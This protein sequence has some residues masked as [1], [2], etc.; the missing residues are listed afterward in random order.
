MANCAVALGMNVIGYDPFMSVSNA[1]RLD[2]AV[3]LMKNNEE[4]M[5]NCDYLTIHVPLTDDTR[6]L[7]N[8]DMIAKMKDG[9][10]I[11]NFS[12]D[13]LVIHG[14]FGGYQERQGRKVR[15]RL[16]Y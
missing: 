1:L 2:P 4:V 6:D 3:K 15:Y 16:W 9:V 7:V 12:R 14:C 8:A 13:G 10:R 11:M 5:T